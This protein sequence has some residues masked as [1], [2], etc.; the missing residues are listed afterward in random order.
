MCLT[1]EWFTARHVR[2]ERLARQGR[3]ELAPFLEEHGLTWADLMAARMLHEQEIHSTA[4]IL[5]HTPT[6]L[7]RDYL[8]AR[9]AYD[10]LVVRKG[11]CPALLAAVQK[12][13][14]HIGAS[15]PR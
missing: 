11:M 15:G 14:P 5:R 9:E 10:I 4:E 6:A 2:L 8:I 13:G 7:G 3:V 12:G 1:L